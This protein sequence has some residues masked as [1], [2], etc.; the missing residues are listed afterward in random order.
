MCWFLYVSISCY[1]CNFKASD[2]PFVLN[3]QELDAKIKERIEGELIYLNGESFIS[4]TT[5]NKIVNE[6]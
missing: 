1:V 2:E 5:M 4:S 3:A 6:T